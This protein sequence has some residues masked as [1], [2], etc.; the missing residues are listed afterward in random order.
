MNSRP[1]V[2]VIVPIFNA[3]DYI[4]RCAHSLFGQTLDDIEYIFV[5]D[6]SPDDS[7]VILDGV[8]AKYPGRQTRVKVLSMAE[9]S[10]QAAARDRGVWESTGEYVIHCDPDDWVDA[11]YY[12]KLYNTAKGGGYDVVTGDF[13]YE[14]DGKTIANDINLDI[15][16]PRDALFTDKHTFFTLWLFMIKSDLIKDNDIHFFPDVNLME[17][18]G[19]VLRAMFFAK[20][21]YHVTDTFYHYR[22]DNP[23]SITAPENIKR[24]SGQRELF[25]KYLDAFLKE[26]GC[27]TEEALCVLRA[28]RDIKNGLLSV[29]TIK[30]WKKTFPEAAVY[31]YRFSEGG[32]L[33]RLTYLMSHFMGSGL[34]KM[35]LKIKGL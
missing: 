32:F 14:Y 27:K 13:L 22:K 31:E 34:M 5:D 6:K 1:K 7:L 16:N 12:E 2:S 33:Y 28:K 3:R 8:L 29:D 25:V 11:D 10:K 26:Q 30:D 18:W 23:R 9:N 17:D 35:F 21:I 4:E 19:F 24:F 15:L 20:S